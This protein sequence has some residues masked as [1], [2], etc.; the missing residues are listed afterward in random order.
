MIAVRPWPAGAV[1]PEPSYPDFAGALKRASHHFA[2]DSG[3]EWGSANACMDR[4]A[5][6]AIN[7]AWPYWAMKRMY[8]E[9]GPLPTFDNFMGVY[10]KRLLAAAKGGAA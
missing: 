6:I 7:A 2:D 9:I 4:A 10:C 5:E 1:C 8:A 3:K